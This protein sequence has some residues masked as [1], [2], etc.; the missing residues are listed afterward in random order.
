MITT[1]INEAPF[2]VLTSSFSI[3]PSTTGYDLEISADGTN[4]SK[5]FTVSANTTKL[6]TNVASGS[7]YRLK[8][9]NGE[10]K[11]NWR[12]NC[13]SG[14]GGDVD[15]TDYYT[16]AQTDSQIQSAVTSA[17]TALE[18]EL[19]NYATSGDIQTINERINTK[20]EVISIALNEL[21]A[22][23]ENIDIP[24]V[25]N[26]V[27]SGDVQTQ[28]TSAVTAIENELSEAEQVTSTALNDINSRMVSSELIKTI[29]KMSQA[30]YDALATKNNETLYIIG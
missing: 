15:L 24:D 12:T 17:I 23:I 9:N 25:S 26:F 18:N 21:H 3:S 7:Y 22:E 10:V 30:E 1:V 11:I 6:V 28:I 16:S 5:L 13:N 2:Q 19:S 8:G 14:G 27:T 4:F 29:V 20:D